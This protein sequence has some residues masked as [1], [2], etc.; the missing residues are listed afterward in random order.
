MFTILSGSST[1]SV[2]YRVRSVQCSWALSACMEP[3]NTKE[4]K[5]RTKV[6]TSFG[7]HF[8]LAKR[9]R[10]SR[11]CQSWQMLLLAKMLWRRSVCFV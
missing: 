6:P 5:K 11:M 7:S 3:K 9:E 2:E 4:T 8:F 10:K 1:S